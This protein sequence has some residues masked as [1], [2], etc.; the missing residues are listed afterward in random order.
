[1]AGETTSHER[2]TSREE[3]RIGSNSTFGL[4]FSIFF[5]A[6]G[7]WPMF[8]GTPPR[9]W[10][11]VLAAIFLFTAILRPT[12]LRHLNYF[13]FRFGLLLHRVV[14]PLIL[15][16]LFYLTIT[17]IALIARLF[18]KDLLHLKLDPEA[19]SYWIKREPPGPTGD[20]MQRQF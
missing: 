15:G 1:M 19:K 6:F 7:L 5:G 14:N 20:S 9:I 12:L 2:L 17:P 16:V 4:V 18:G 8:A 3:V 13:W 11:L 10:A